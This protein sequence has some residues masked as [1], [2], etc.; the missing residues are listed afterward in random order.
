[1]KMPKQSQRPWE[2]AD[3]RRPNLPAAFVLPNEPKLAFRIN[4]LGFLPTNEAKDLRVFNA[5]VS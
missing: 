4:C 5:L 3:F 2:T 1:M